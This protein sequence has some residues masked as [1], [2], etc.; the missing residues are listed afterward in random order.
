MT[1]PALS[2]LVQIDEVWNLN[3]YLVS[4]L[5]FSLFQIVFSFAFIF[6]LYLDKSSFL[7]FKG[8]NSYEI[9][10]FLAI[11]LCTLMA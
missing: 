4:G 3:Y 1:R 10:S 9:I 7:F 11:F 5:E 8:L 6:Q 2:L